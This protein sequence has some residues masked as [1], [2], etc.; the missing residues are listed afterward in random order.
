MKRR[1]IIHQPPPQWIPLPQPPPQPTDS[2]TAYI[3]KL[4]VLADAMLNRAKEANEHKTQVLS[5]VP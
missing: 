2:L 3:A 4:Q 5:D 1:F